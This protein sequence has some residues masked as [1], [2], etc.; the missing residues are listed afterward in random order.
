M[1]RWSDPQYR[2][3][4]RSPLNRNGH[5]SQLVDSS[6]SWSCTVGGHLENHGGTIIS[7]TAGNHSL[8]VRAFALMT[9][10]RRY[11]SAPAEPALTPY[12]G[13][14]RRTLW[15]AHA[16]PNL[17]PINAYDLY[18]ALV[19]SGRPA[20]Q[21]HLR[22]GAA[23]ASSAIVLAI[24]SVADAPARAQPAVRLL[25]TFGILRA[26]FRQSSAGYRWN[27]CTTTST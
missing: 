23:T 4:S 14:V 10:Q 13:G 8:H 20:D 9:T 24:K 25:G 1:C 26:A 11:Q 3:T 2:D 19:G 17:S 5:G 16:S 15:G 6:V 27:P 12:R 18:A 7:H 21:A 22:H